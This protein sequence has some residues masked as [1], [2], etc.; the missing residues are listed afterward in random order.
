MIGWLEL[1]SLGVGYDNIRGILAGGLFGRAL[2]VLVLSKVVSWVIYLKS[3]TSGGTLAPLLTFGGGLGA[4][5]GRAAAAWWPALGNDTY[6]R[7]RTT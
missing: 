1:R 7:Q 6:G 5:L 2:V 4:L 3:G